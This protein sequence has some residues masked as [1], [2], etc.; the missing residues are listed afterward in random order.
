MACGNVE[1]E[2]RGEGGGRG[3][4]GVMVVSSK[5]VMNEKN[6]AVRR[7]RTPRA[8]REVLQGL[9]AQP[10]PPTRLRGVGEGR[11]GTMW[12]LVAKIFEFCVILLYN[13]AP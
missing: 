6:G 2:G 4:E 1:R 12:G 8:T 10:M 5:Q 3:G 9:W 11:C 13:L 7:C